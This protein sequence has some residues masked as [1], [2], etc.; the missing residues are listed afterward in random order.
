MG[1]NQNT[2]D[3]DEL[4]EKWSSAGNVYGSGCQMN[5]TSPNAIYK[6]AFSDESTQFFDELVKCNE[7]SSTEPQYKVSPWREKKN[8]SKTEF[9]VIKQRKLSIKATE[10]GIA[11]FLRKNITTNLTQTAFFKDDSVIIY[12]VAQ[13]KVEKQ[14]SDHLI[15]DRWTIKN[16]INAEKERKVAVTINANILWKKYQSP[17]AAIIKSKWLRFY[18]SR[19]ETWRRL[20]KK[21]VE[22]HNENLYVIH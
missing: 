15:I 1:M 18:Q 4:T 5:N 19:F 7:S 2:T 16:M 22:R 6:L 8:V 9:N 20:I 14:A 12:S 21:Y 13:T 17:T 10:S 3:F 11:F